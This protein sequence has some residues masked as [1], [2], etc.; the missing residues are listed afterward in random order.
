MEF[1]KQ[2]ISP[3]LRST[4]F[5]IQ[6]VE[7]TICH[8]YIHYAAN[9]LITFSLFELVLY[10]FHSTEVEEVPHP[11]EDRHESKHYRGC[12]LML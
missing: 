9:L 5:F 11:F 4:T 10:Y 2:Q 8:S 6:I 1:L 7:G 3:L 12:S